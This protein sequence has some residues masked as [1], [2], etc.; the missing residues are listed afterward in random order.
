M[1]GIP[2]TR[3]KKD[4]AGKRWSALLLVVLLILESTVV[5]FHTMIA[6]LGISNSKFGILSCYRDFELF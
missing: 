4:M 2:G 6:L 1:I 5:T 3:T